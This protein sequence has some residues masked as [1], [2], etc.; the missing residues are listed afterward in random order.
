VNLHFPKGQLNFCSIHDTKRDISLCRFPA[1]DSID[2]SRSRRKVALGPSS[3][4]DYNGGWIALREENR[5][6]AGGRISLLGSS[7]GIE[8]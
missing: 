1:D 5:Y 6:A 7:A 8:D 2:W 3:P 4:F